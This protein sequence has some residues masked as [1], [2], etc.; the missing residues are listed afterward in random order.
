[1]KGKGKFIVI[2]GTDGSG[3]T[4]QTEALLLRFKKEHI[5]AE[6]IRFPQYEKNLFGG[7]IRECLDGKRGDFISL[8]PKITSVLYACD[9]FET[10]PRIKEW[11]DAGKIVVADR[12]V[13]SNQIHQGGK[14]RDDK[15]RARFLNWLESMEYGTLGVLKPDAIIYLDMSYEHSLELISRREGI[16]DSADSNFEYL[17][18]SKDAGKY[19]LSRESFWHRVDCERNGKL[20]SIPEVHEL[21][22]AAVQKI[23]L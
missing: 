21:V 14:I 9:R 17:K 3:K 19:M 13:S 6:S 20:L 1:M 2:E 22:Y 15:K 8:D 5:P 11:L 12:Y 10:V 23:L 18:N 4:T 16:R 7:L